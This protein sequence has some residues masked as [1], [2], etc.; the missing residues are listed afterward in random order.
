MVGCNVMTILKVKGEK[1][2]EK[3]FPRVIQ[4]GN[5]GTETQTVQ[6]W[7]T[8]SHPCRIW[9]DSIVQCR[10]FTKVLFDPSRKVDCLLALWLYSYIYFSLC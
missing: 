10:N 1:K 8:C 3:L 9:I 4:L 2:T 7:P 6:L 5:H